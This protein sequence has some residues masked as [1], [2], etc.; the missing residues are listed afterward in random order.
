MPERRIMEQTRL[1]VDEIAASMEA[2]RARLDHRY[3]RVLIAVLVIAVIS[4]G[5]V[6]FG[7]AI[8]RHTDNQAQQNTVALCALRRD[9]E[10]RVV[11]SERFIQEHPKGIPGIPVKTLIQS[12]E[13]QKRTIKALS[14]IKCPAPSDS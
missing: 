3:S 1:R 7:F 12:T 10:D 14:P 8:L 9:L 13:G 2:Y 11:S 6:V 4:I 5:S